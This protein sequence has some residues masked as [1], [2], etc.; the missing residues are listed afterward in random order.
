MGKRYCASEMKTEFH[1]RMRSEDWTEGIK[2]SLITVFLSI[3]LY[4]RAKLVSTTGKLS[5]TV[6]MTSFI[7]VS[8]DHE[9][10]ET[11]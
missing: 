11:S 9:V 8:R 2:E 4:P 3:Y 1:K 6:N 5:V 10:Q 7:A